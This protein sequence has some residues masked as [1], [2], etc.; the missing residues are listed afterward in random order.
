MEKVI[1]KP[2]ALRGTIS[3][4]ADKSITHRAILLS[5]LANGT[6]TIENPLLADD[7]LSTARCME[8]LGVKIE[9]SKDKWTIHGKGL[10]SFV[11]PRNDLDCG[12][13]GTTMRLLSGVLSAQNFSC[14]LV[15]DASLSKRPMTRI[16]QPLSKMGATFSLTDDKYAPITITGTKNLKPLQWKNNVA[17]AQVKSSVLLAALH[18]KGETVYDEPTVSRDHTERMFTGA[19]IRFQREGTTIRIE[20]PQTP[21]PQNWVVPSDISSAAFFV[22]AASLFPNANVRLLAVN[23]NPTRTG[24]LDILKSA[25]GAVQLEHERTIGGEQ[26]ADIVVNSQKEL[27]AFDIDKK[28]SPRLIDEIPILALA[29]TQ[30]HGTSNFSGLEELRVKETDRLKALTKNFRAMGAR[31]EEISDGL[32]ITG[33]TKL[34]GAKV[35][36]FHDHRVAMTFAIAGLIAEGDTTIQNSECVAI[37]FP[38]FWD[39]LNHLCQK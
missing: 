36:S 39:L 35:D 24:L 33:P 7:C 34:R 15:G 10:W 2:S 18:T 23:T 4:P 29:A 31:I 38:T 13:S 3:V 9:R 28:I 30:A 25:G 26:I 1:R 32:K 12:N 6:S 22:I 20:G 17:S 27:K 37:S 11:A 5:S 8:E 21:T 14:R 16:S 19:G